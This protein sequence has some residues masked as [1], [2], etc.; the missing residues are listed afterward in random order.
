MTKHRLKLF[1]TGHSDESK[2]AIENMQ[3]ICKSE[4][5]GKCDFSI[6]DLLEY[7]QLAENE[8]ILATPTL[9]K[10]LPHPVVRIIGDLSS[11]EKIFQKLNL[12]F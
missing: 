8:K 11:R 9:I 2:C 1:I 3:S 4:M 10:E 6:I 7:P 12:K 5:K